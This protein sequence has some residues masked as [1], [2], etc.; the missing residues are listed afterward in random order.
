MSKE[1][2][3]EALLKLEFSEM[4]AN[5][6]QELELETLQ[7]LMKLRELEMM[8]K[9]NLPLFMQ[10]LT[11]GRNFLQGIPS[12]FG[13]LGLTPGHNNLHKIISDTLLPPLDNILHNG[14]NLHGHQ[15]LSPVMAHSGLE[16][17]TGISLFNQQLKQEVPNA[18]QRDKVIDFIGYALTAILMATVPQIGMIVAMTGIMP[19][20]LSCFKKDKMPKMDE[21]ATAQ[22]K[23]L[24]LQQESKL[25]NYLEMAQ[26][27]SNLSHTMDLNAL[28]LAKYKLMPKVID[29]IN[30]VLPKD[31]GMNALLEGAINFSKEFIP[32]SSGTPDQFAIMRDDAVTQM[33]KQHLPQELI[34]QAKEIFNREGEAF[35]DFATKKMAEEDNK[36]VDKII[37]CNQHFIESVEKIK[38]SII[39]KAGEA[40]II[41]NKAEDKNLEQAVEKPHEQKLAEEGGVE[42]EVEKNNI[43]RKANPEKDKAEVS[44]ILT[45]IF[46]P[47]INNANQCVKNI[48]TAKTNILGS[49]IAKEDLGMNMV[50]KL[51]LSKM[52]QAAGLYSGWQR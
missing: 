21:L 41:D 22:E 38:K 9:R 40:K 12:H 33:E 10:Q 25:A 6:N 48:Y 52:M 50:N 39:E 45:G 43:E 24:Q 36:A 51:Y 46:L 14:V 23:L 7:E 32:D 5:A 44:K 19:K 37:A 29:K 42:P 35:K 47:K 8:S 28:D 27:L 31:N 3:N 11:A 15:L 49:A 2:I 30:N 13:N 16:L 1:N 18:D 34:A 17:L 20:I 26:S 4:L